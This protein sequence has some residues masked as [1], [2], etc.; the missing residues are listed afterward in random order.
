MIAT[1]DLKRAPVP[2]CGAL[3]AASERTSR[4]PTYLSERKQQLSE[5]LADVQTEPGE[6]QESVE[7]VCELIRDIKVAM[8]TATGEDGTLHSRPMCTQQTD[9]DGQVWFASS[10]SSSLIKQLMTNPA[11]LVQYAN[12]ESQRFVILAGETAVVNEGDKK[13]ELG[14][15]IFEMDW[16]GGP[17]DPNLTLVHLSSHPVDY[18][19]AP[20][21]SAPFSVP[22]LRNQRFTGCDSL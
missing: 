3:F 9:L 4:S 21:R 22:R 11:V 18:W 15:P 10:K 5:P 13:D 17:T 1:V 16:K 2:H 8:L 20:A 12:P 6:S 14:N 19:D 7:K